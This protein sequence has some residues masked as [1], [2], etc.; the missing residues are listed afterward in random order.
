MD[1]LNFHD[2][3]DYIWEDEGLEIIV[4]TSYLEKNDNF[5]KNFTLDIFRLYELSDFPP[6]YFRKLI[7]I[8]FTNLFI[9][10]PGTKNI[11]EIS[12]DFRNSDHKG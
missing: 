12:D 7:E 11:K 9:F 1:K 8:M 5:I 2:F 6:Q 3:F 4:S 10:N